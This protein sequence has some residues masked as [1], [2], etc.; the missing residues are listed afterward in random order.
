MSAL[1]NPIAFTSFLQ[2]LK[3]CIF[4]LSTSKDSGS[5][6]E[7]TAKPARKGRKRQ[8]TQVSDDEVV[9]DDDDDVVA[10]TQRATQKSGRGTQQAA[11]GSITFGDGQNMLVNVASFVEAFGL[12]DHEDMMHMLLDMCVE[13]IYVCPPP[14]TSVRNGA[15]KR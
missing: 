13:V 14:K 10:P 12:S 11:G 4:G 5:G 1:F 8:A 6:K 15:G 9:D 3:R 2:V 7:A